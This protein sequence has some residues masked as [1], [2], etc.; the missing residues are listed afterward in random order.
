M[1]SVFEGVDTSMHAM[2]LAFLEKL[3]VENWICV[4]ER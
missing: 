3:A 2:N 4:M 1:G